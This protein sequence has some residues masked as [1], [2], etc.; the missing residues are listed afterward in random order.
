MD[1]LLIL[2]V[3]AVLF[4]PKYKG[5]CTMWS[6]SVNHGVRVTVWVSKPRRARYRLGL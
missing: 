6:G 2:Y 4:N 5:A 1:S 3:K